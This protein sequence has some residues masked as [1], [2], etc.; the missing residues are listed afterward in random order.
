MSIPS[1]RIKVTHKIAAI[2]AAGVIGLMVVGACYFLGTAHQERLQDRAD[3]ADVIAA[4]AREARLNMLEAR[5]WEKDFVQRLNETDAARHAQAA[6]AASAK[7][8]ILHDSL[9][10]IGK[11]DLADH[12]DAI[13]NV[14]GTYVDQFKSLTELHR[15]L[16]LDQYKGLEGSLSASV[17][18]I[19]NKL[20]AFDE[21]RLSTLMLTMRRREKDYQMRFT[22]RYLDQMRAAAVAFAE[23]VAKSDL[24]AA[25]KRELTARLSDYQRDFFAW[26]A[27]AQESARAQEAMSQ[28]YAK[29]E[30]MLGIFATSIAEYKDATEAANIASRAHT[31]RNIQ[32][33]ILATLLVVSAFVL[34]V[35]RSIAKPLRAMTRG[36][37]RLMD[38]DF[39]VKLPQ[40]VRSDEIGDMARTVEGFKVK[41]IAR[42]RRE[43]EE[44]DARRRAADEARKTDMHRL[45]DAFEKAVGNVVQ[46]VSSASTELEATA[47]ALTHTAD[48][49]G[50]LA[51]AVASASE[52]ASIN[53]RSVAAATEE[54]TGAVTEIGRQAQEST[55]IA[56]AAVRQSGEADGH[57][58]EL[59]AA[60]DR[61]GDVVKL[62]A[63][64]AGQTNLLAL[65]A[66]IEAA[67]AGESGRGFA[68]VASEVK[69]L[70]TQTAK[71]TE[72]I[73][74]Q[75]GSMQAA[76]RES[77]SAIKAIGGTVGRVSEIAALI[78]ESVERQSVAM[79]EISRNV[80]SAS[81]G[82]A[83]VA[84]NINDVNRG[85]EETGSAS[86]LVLASAHALASE[87]ARLKS[88]LDHFLQGIRAA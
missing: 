7:L 20:D 9:A 85:A 68:I 5:G 69:T 38:G 47:T 23:A 1:I 82:T 55:R 14:F 53:V 22:P 12:V 64:I 35:G 11:G 87:S 81:Q 48:T 6:G 75:I 37:G 56:N 66:T 16:G 52:E 27:T 21:P 29:V 43:A 78:A 86:A 3:Q 34:W 17:H 62:I 42:A 44:E 30:P 77:F 74:S 49:T 33:A 26:V 63:A 80:H 13:R 88:E 8:S 72:E 41:A 65:N 71:A 18:A 54:I 19:E 36:M 51:G 61:I 70:A 45:A 58:A 46:T 40:L 57:M 73:R 25:D 31:S 4:L 10:E 76:T 79:L 28:T 83:Q 84:S 60:A 39:D 50:Q 15:K 32:L 24:A 2:G 59:S 67:R